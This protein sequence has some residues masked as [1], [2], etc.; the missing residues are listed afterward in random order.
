[1]KKTL[2]LIALCITGLSMP[3]HGYR[4]R[5]IN[6]RTGKLKDGTVVT[7]EFKIRLYMAVCKDRDFPEDGSVIPAAKI[8]MPVQVLADGTPAAGQIITK[9]GL[10]VWGIQLPTTYQLISDRIVAWNADPKVATVVL[11]E[12]A[13]DGTILWG[14]YTTSNGAI[15]KITPNDAVK[16]IKIPAGQQLSNAG[17]SAPS[18]QTF[19]LGNVCCFNSASVG[20]KAPYPEVKAGMHGCTNFT[21]K[22]YDDKMVAKSDLGQAIVE[23]FENIGKGIMTGLTFG[24]GKT[25]AGYF[26]SA[27]DMVAAIPKQIT[28]ATADIKTMPTTIDDA[29]IGKAA[30]AGKKA[31]KGLDEQ[32]RGIQKSMNDVDAHKKAVV[33]MH[34]ENRKINDLTVLN[35]ELQT[36]FNTLKIALQSLVADNTC[37]NGALCDLKAALVKSASAANTGYSKIDTGIKDISSQINKKV[38][39]IIARLKG[40]AKVLNP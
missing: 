31:V 25:L 8:V 5:V 22:V 3:L 30:T 14:Q 40:T 11:V 15:T 39:G 21:I 27:A 33:D 38:V 2:Q 19:D 20:A 13:A 23:G 29:I 37:S 34:L 32:I 10:K 16:S 7:G 4:V 26:N 35:T 17:S 6:Y 18:V 36:A 9:P 28:D 12:V 24:Q 1:M